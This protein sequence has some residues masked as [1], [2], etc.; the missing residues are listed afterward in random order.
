M[1]IELP[2]NLTKS[3]FCINPKESQS[4]RSIDAFMV[5]VV[6][7]QQAVMKLEPAKMLSN[8]D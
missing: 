1:K 4:T 2:Y 6:V 3:L 5:K 8:N 7:P